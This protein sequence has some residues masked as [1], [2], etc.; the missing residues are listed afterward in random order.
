MNAPY[1]PYR[2]PGDPSGFQGGYQGGFQP[3]AGK[4]T[5]LMVAGILAI[6]FGALGVIFGLFGALTAFTTP[7]PTG[8]PVMDELQRALREDALISVQTKINA[9][10]GPLAA[11]ALLA[12]GIGLVQAKEWGRK[13]TLYWA[14]YAV[15]ATM[16][17]TFVT[18][19]RMLPL[20]DTMLQKLMSKFPGQN[21]DTA[22][23]IIKASMVGGVVI[24]LLFGLALPVAMTLMV[25]RQRVKDACT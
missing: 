15:V 18:V 19:T 12:A 4:P 24:G 1:D 16:F 20:V 7:A 11:G 6:I 2:P 5:I 22:A 23:S 8:D 10:A 25:T 9:V 13:L 3:K 17:S 14:V 21:A